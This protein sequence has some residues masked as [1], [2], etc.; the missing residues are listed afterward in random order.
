[1]G[2]KF[3][4]G[5]P[6]GGSSSSWSSYW[7]T[8]FVSGHSATA[9]SSSQINL[10][11]INNGTADYN[12][13]LIYRT[14]NPDGVTDRVLIHT[15]AVGTTTY[16]DTGLTYNHYYYS[17]RYVKGTNYS[18]F[19]S[20]VFNDVPTILLDGNTIWY[21]M[22]DLAKITKNGSNEV[23]KI[24]EKLAA[25]VLHDLN[26][27][28]PTKL[29]I[30]SADGIT[31]DGSNDFMSTTGGDTNGEFSYAQPIAVYYAVRS[32][33]WQN[34][35]SFMDG[36]VT[37]SVRYVLFNY[38]PA[39]ENKVSI[40]SFAYLESLTFTPNVFHTVRMFFNGAA[41]RLAIDNG[42][43]LRGNAGGNWMNGITLWSLKNGT[44]NINATFKDAI[45]RKLQETEYNAS[46]INNYL[47]RKNSLSSL[48]NDVLQISVENYLSKK[49]GAFI[50]WSFAT[51]AG[52]DFIGPD[53]NPDIFAPTTTNAQAMVNDWLDMFV[54]AGM[55]YAIFDAKTND[56]WCMWPTVFADP[57]HS[58]YGIGSTAWYAANGNPD[59]VGLFVAGCNARGLM[60]IL[61]FSV[62]DT[63]HEARTSTDETTDAAAYIAMIQAQLTELLS[64]YGTIG[65]IW[66]D[67]Y[68]WHISYNNIPY[69]ACYNTIKA[70]QPACLVMNNEHDIVPQYNSDIV[71]NELVAGSD[72]PAIEGN[73]NPAEDL[74]CIR[75][76]Q[77]WNYNDED[78]QLA[79]AFRSKAYINAAR[80]R[81][82]GRTANYC[83]TITPDYSGFIPVAQK[84]IFESLT[85]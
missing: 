67:G 41:S 16:S 13:I 28:T 5:V 4:N 49:F 83:I 42:S 60:P 32:G 31:G 45:F 82:N 70:L 27:T 38:Y 36:R 66:L 54:T 57:E 59:F 14:T 68:L 40:F 76:D 85:T 17:F 7:M 65:G 46:V 35:R 29:P 48:T 9:V 84:A 23:S 3:I 75:I 50:C 72:D 10:A 78:S 64:N 55:K 51:F 73:R 77:H 34:G 15:A 20:V 24:Q 44:G 26:Q 37:S 47:K 22:T 74:D 39:V 81:A 43:Y 33:S 19:S 62:L 63:T 11:W 25:N 1:M 80:T 8:R 6:I 53:Q 61:Y 12:N 21:D 56:G 18:P 79:A 69:S 30:H 58:P 2:W 71:L 52:N